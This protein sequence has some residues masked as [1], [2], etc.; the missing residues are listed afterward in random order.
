MPL[1]LEFARVVAFLRF[2]DALLIPKPSATGKF[3]ILAIYPRTHTHIHTDTHANTRAKSVC[4]IQYVLFILCLFLSH[5]SVRFNFTATPGQVESADPHKKHGGSVTF[6]RQPP[7]QG[8][9]IKYVISVEEA[10]RL[11]SQCCPCM[12]F[13]TM[14]LTGWTSSCPPCLAQISL[15]MSLWDGWRP[16][17]SCVPCRA[18]AACRSVKV[19][20]RLYL[21]LVH[22]GYYGTK[23]LWLTFPMETFILVS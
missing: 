14:T 18:V 17:I 19:I 9:H 23:S 10:S 12:I 15:G 21:N 2:Y 22:P 1:S 4:E 7:V 5:S 13:F 20:S 6:M 8:R 3:I 11:S 16:A